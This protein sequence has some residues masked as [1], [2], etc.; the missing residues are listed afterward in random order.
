MT[1]G[2]GDEGADDEEG[3]G[4]GVD[5]EG[6]CAG[7]AARLTAGDLA[8]VPGGAN[9]KKAMELGFY[10]AE[11]NAIK[12]MQV[13]DLKQNCIK[14]KITYEKKEKAQLALMQAL[15]TKYGFALPRAWLPKPILAVLDP[16]V[17]E[18]EAKRANLRPSPQK[19]VLGSALDRAA[20]LFARGEAR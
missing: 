11:I 6:G 20:A 14:F 12:G 18:Q 19:M 10:K 8:L 9:C 3:G 15:S 17:V 2:R 13:P 16:E 7:G 5:G 1:R 4:G